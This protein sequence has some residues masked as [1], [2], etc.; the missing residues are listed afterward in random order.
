MTS[1]DLKKWMEQNDFTVVDIASVLKL[2]PKTVMNYLSGKRVHRST[3]N[4]LSSLIDRP[5]PERRK[6][7]AFS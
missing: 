6:I 4:L 2:D 7:P 1:Q 3:E 5:T